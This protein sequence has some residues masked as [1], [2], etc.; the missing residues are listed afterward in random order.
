MRLG[1]RQ[2]D[3]MGRCGQGRKAGKWLLGTSG[4]RRVRQMAEDGTVGEVL[5]YCDGFAVGY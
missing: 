4:I 1:K 3:Q 5:S 2:L